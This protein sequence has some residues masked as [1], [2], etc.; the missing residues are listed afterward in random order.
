MP[1]TGTVY[2]DA[3]LSV[4]RQRAVGDGFH[5]ELTILNHDDEPVDLDGSHRRGAATS[6][7][8]SRSR[9]RSRRKGATPREVEKGQPRARLRARDLQARDL[10]LGDRTGASSTRQG[11]TF[12]VHLEPHGAVDDRPRG[13]HRPSGAGGADARPKYERGQRKAQPNM[14][15]SLERWLAEAPRL[16]CD[17]ELAQGDLPAQPRRPRRAAL[18]AADR[19]RARACRP[20]A[21]RG[22]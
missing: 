7:T 17:W 18:L 12:A 22:S 19:R 10:D 13:R 6:P 16:E 1:G 8:C 3:K 2:V 4:I 11:L 21:C 9:M 5:E 15:R 14:E 20:P